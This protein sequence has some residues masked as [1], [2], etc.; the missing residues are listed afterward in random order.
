M[1]LY[2]FR[3]PGLVRGKL[4]SAN[5]RAMKPRSGF[6]FAGRNQLVHLV[7]AGEV[8][9]RLGRGVA[10]H[11]HRSTQAAER[12]PDGNQPVSFYAACLILPCGSDTLAPRPG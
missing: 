1:R 6:R 11:L 7:E 10:E 9:Q 12:F 4:H 8:V 3:V 5:S 2:S